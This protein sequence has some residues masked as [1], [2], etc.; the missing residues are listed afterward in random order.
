MKAVAAK[1]VPGFDAFDYGMHSLRIG[2]EAELR[3]AKVRP[4]LINDI[5]SHTTI[6]GRAPY[7]RQERVELL[8][9]NRLA[10]GAV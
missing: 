4:E 5:T 9:A 3:C 7:S 10:D 1:V 8:Q 6:G 2:R